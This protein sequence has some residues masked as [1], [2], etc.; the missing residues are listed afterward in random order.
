MSEAT[1]TSP[2]PA[3]QDPSVSYV[4]RAR[5]HLDEHWARNVPLDE[6]ADVA[7]VSK[8]HLARR[9]AS[10]VGMPPHAY[11][12]RLRVQRAMTMLREGASVYQVALR[13]GFSDA[14]HLCR[15]FKR[16]AGTTPGR[17]ARGH[18]PQGVGARR[19]N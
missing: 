9:F 4:L 2:L 8:F 16:F 5:E 19:A 11:Q 18:D 14:S 7:G 12:N 15:H 10:V 1:L 17:F 13:T 3:N 6:L